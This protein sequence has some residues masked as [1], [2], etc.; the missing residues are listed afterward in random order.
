MSMFADMPTRISVIIPS[1]NSLF[2]D[3]TLV[4]VKAQQFD[5]SSV[6]VL[7]VG[8]DDAG[9]VQEDEWVQFVSTGEPVWPGTARNIGAS[10]ATGEVFVFL[11]ADC[12]AR[13][14]WLARLID[15]FCNSVV[16]VVG[17]GVNFEF[18]NYWALCDNL[19]VFHEQLAGTSRATRPVLASINLAVRRSA[20]EAIG[21]FD[22]SYHTRASEDVDFVLRLRQQGYQLFFEPEAVVTHLGGRRTFRD[23]W[24]HTWVFGQYSTRVRPEYA[25]QRGGPGFL[26]HWSSLGLLSPVVAAGLTLRAFRHRTLWRYWYAA[27]GIFLAKWAWT[28]GAAHRLWLRAR[29]QEGE[30]A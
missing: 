28:L 3:R 15:R 21:G 6:E 20:F 16:A 27:P 18:D 22:D 24:T 26:Q 17:G 11:D 30:L 1:L 14:D 5:L 29:G 4:S 23:M 10:H 25:D 13:P 8:L 9:C 7:V 19:S 12:V 2:I